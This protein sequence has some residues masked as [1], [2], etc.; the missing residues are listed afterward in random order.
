MAN[1]LILSVKRGA[2]QVSV[3]GPLLFLAYANGT[4]SV[5]ECT[6]KLFADDTKIYRRVS[7][8]TPTE[9][10]SLQADIDILVAWSRQVAAPN[11]EGKCKGLHL[12]SGNS[13]LQYTMRG[14]SL[15][16]MDTERH[17]DIHID[18]LLKFHKQAAAVAAKTNQVLAVIKCSF[19]LI[20]ACTLP[21]VCPHPEFGN[22]IWTLFNRDD[23]LLVERI[24]LRAT[25]LVSSVRLRPYEE[26][27]E[28]LDLRS[29][30][31]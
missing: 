25:H 15:A 1:T 17:L 18:T 21:L 23:Q 10:A 26:R 27:L 9:S 30:F 11:H 28:A 16:E 31:Y 13:R 4:P 19:E 2:P 6:A 8:A 7:T 3:L 5:V 29:L 22:V 12:C 24:Q 14:V 20:D